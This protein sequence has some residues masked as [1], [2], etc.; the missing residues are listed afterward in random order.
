M[1]IPLATTTIS[2]IGVR[3][4]SPV[5]PDAEGFDGP[6][7]TPVPLINGVRASITQPKPERGTDGNDEQD[8]YTLSC[9]PIDVGLTRY[10]TVVDEQTGTTYEVKKVA[11]SPA[12]L[13]GLDHV[14]ATLFKREGLRDV[15]TTS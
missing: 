5:D 2:I 7:P 14:K 10:D 1:A 15:A 13:L 4:Q 3:P 8:L 9:D 12:T 11:A 6:G